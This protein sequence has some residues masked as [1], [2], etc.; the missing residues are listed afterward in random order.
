MDIIGAVEGF[1]WDEGNKDKNWIRHKVQTVECEAIFFNQP[2]VI[3]DDEKHSEKEKRIY[4]YGKTNSNRKLLVVFCIRNKKIRVI[5][6]R[7]MDKNER[8]Y[9]EE[10]ENTEF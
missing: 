4:A 1:E 5:S 7:D 6:A 9:Y 10:Q 8:K 3:I 2:L